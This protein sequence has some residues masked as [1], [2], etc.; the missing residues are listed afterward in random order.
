M[1]PGLA[2]PSSAGYPRRPHWL[3]WLARH[4]DQFPKF[5]DPTDVRGAA[6]SA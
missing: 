1:A 3:I 6:V 5:R 4:L 2:G